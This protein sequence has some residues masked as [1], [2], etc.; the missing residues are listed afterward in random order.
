MEQKRA[1]VEWKAGLLLALSGVALIAA[2]ALSPIPNPDDWETFYGVGHYVWNGTPLY[3]KPITFAYYFNPPWLAVLLSPFTLLSFRW[4]WAVLCV[5]SL[6]LTA[7]LARRWQIGLI[8]LGLT[9]LSPAMVYILLHGQVDALILGGLLLPAEW[10]IIVALT[11]P[12]V[13]VGLMFGIERG[14]WPRAAA[15]TILIVLLSLLVFGNW[16]LRF[17]RQPSSVIEGTVYA[18]HNLWRNLWPYQLPAGV[19][20]LLLGLRRRDARF[21][22]GASPLLSPYTPMSGLLG[23][24]LALASLLNDWEAGVVWLTWWGAVLYR[25]F[26]P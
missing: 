4:S 12:Q 26:V 24:W 16:P 8:R 3:D 15:I 6:G 10:W 13:A 20:V 18:T 9:V 14:R 25:Y 1:P 7:A 23:S 17:I 19:G 21:L 11:K 2:F 5:V 22:L